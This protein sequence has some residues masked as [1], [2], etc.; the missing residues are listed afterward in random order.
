MADAFVR[1][2]SEASVPERRSP[3][4]PSRYQPF[5][6]RGTRATLNERIRVYIF[7]IHPCRLTH[8]SI[9]MRRLH[10]VLSISLLLVFAF[11][12]LADTPS[13]STP[14][15]AF[16]INPAGT[17]PPKVDDNSHNVPN[18]SASFTTAQTQ[19][20]FNPPD[21][22]PSGHPSMPDIVAHA[23]SPTFTRAV[24]VTCPTDWDVRRTPASLDCP[25]VTSF[26]R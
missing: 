25:S 8:Y 21:W 11:I 12:A 23:E 14:Y 1:P 17:A 19:D 24:T 2:A 10:P 26:T 16:C 5:P 4:Y 22:H 20:L 18:S 9:C 7:R 13:Q 3:Y 15:W 6:L